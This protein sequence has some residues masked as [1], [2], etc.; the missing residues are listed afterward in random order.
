MWNKLIATLIRCG[1][2]LAALSIA[3]SAQAYGQYWSSVYNCPG[4]S[5][6]QI[7][8]GYTYYGDCR[9]DGN[10]YTLGT[11][12]VGTSIGADSMTALSFVD[13]SYQVI[14]VHAVVRIEGETYAQGRSCDYQNG[15]YDINSGIYMIP[16]VW[17][18]IW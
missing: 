10:G 6:S 11:A 12:L 1:L 15:C 16:Y 18:M 3:T 8:G 13:E 5:V 14:E 17:A 9:L 2:I 7:Q 4:Y